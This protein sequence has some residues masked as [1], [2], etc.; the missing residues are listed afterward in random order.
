EKVFEVYFSGKK[1]GTFF[2]DLMVEEKIIVEVKAVTG[3]MPVLFRNQ[4]IAYLRASKL[5]TAL[6][7]NFGNKSCEVKRISL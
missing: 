7:V 4:V 3:I 5:K 1:V 2:C 6:L